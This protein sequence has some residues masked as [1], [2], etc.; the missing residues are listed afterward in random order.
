MCVHVYIR[1]LVLSTSTVSFEEGPPTKIVATHQS[2]GWP[3]SVR[4]LPIP[5]PQERG[6]Q[7]CLAVLLSC[8]WQRFKHRLPCV[9]GKQFPVWA[10]SLALNE[11][12]IR[13]FRNKKKILKL[14]QW[15]KSKTRELTSHVFLLQ[16]KPWSGIL[17]CQQPK[18][19]KSSPLPQRVEMDRA[20]AFPTTGWLGQRRHLCYHRRQGQIC[21]SVT[22]SARLTSPDIYTLILNQRLVRNEGFA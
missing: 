22:V 4:N 20:P 7:I 9:W 17:A 8:M 3:V 18:T 2:H 21:W 14:A 1:C 13:D 5:I 16:S 19:N 15:S 11:I 10:F 12:L 6:L